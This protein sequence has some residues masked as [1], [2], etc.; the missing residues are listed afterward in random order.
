MVVPS[1]SIPDTK[2]TLRTTLR[3]AR[4]DY[5]AGLPETERLALA[6]ALIPCID[7]LLEGVSVV[8]GYAARGSE[9]PVDAVLR[10]A[11]NRGISA[12]Y[13]AFTTAASPMVFRS[14]QCAE[15]CP[16][17]G[18]QPPHQARVVTPDLILVP[19]LAADRRG[20]RLGQGGGHYDRAL[21]ALRAEGARIIG[22]G[23]TMQLVETLLPVEPWDIPLDGF[24]SP[25]GLVEFA[26]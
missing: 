6:E 25:A 2:A 15:D 19:L 12:A 11:M 22:V 18:V 8:A 20:T 5:F 26:A 3:R 13:P 16:V 17:G 9:L 1:P 7:P 23:W 10:H 14:G 4:R 24:A 21:P